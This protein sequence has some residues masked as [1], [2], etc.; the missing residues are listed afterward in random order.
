MDGYLPTRVRVVR[1]IEST[2]LGHFGLWL[3]LFEPLSRW[4]FLVAALMLPSMVG[5]FLLWW[6]VHLGAAILVSLCL[7]WFFVRTLKGAGLG[8]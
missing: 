4:R 2:L 7:T 5:V 8:N 6:N 3:A 1:G